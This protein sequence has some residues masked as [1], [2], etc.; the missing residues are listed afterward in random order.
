MD[1]VIAEKRTPTG[2]LIFEFSIVIVLAAYGLLLAR[3]WSLMQL[4]KL[5]ARF[6]QEEITS[7]LT[8]KK[9][10]IEN[11]KIAP[12][13]GESLTYEEMRSALADN[14]MRLESCKAT[15]RTIGEMTTE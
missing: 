3:D 4:G 7:A 6:A 10:T 13:N 11:K 9:F 5:K 12:V 8:G 14:V 1:K 2:W 15:M